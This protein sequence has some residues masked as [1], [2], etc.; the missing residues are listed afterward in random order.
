MCCKVLLNIHK[1]NQPPLVNEDLRAIRDMME[2]SSRFLS[3]SGLS[4]I[5]AGL[6]AIAGAAVAWFFILE[7]GFEISD[8]YFSE[9]TVGNI[10]R[11]RFLLVVDAGVVLIAAII[12][13]IILSSRKANRSGEKLLNRVVARMV[14]DLLIPLVAG[15]IFSLCFLLN[16]DSIYIAPAMLV[17]YGIALV[18]GSRHTYGEVRYLGLL[19]IITGLAALLLPGYGL[20]FW[21][22]GFGVLHIGYGLVIQR[23]YH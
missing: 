23:K 20:L 21:V 18:N 1:M 4:G 8:D 11:I 5:V 13:S 10:E 19:E 2:K 6:F 15:G 14:A 16:G 7:K 22:A 12:S 3:L 9:I 17:F